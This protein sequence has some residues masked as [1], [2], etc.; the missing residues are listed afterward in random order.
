MADEET[1]E[2]YELQDNESWEERTLNLLHNSKIDQGFTQ[3]NGRKR[4]HKIS[5][6]KKRPMVIPSVILELQNQL[7]R[8]SSLRCLSNFLLEVV[9]LS[10]L[11]LIYLC[12][13]IWVCQLEIML[14]SIFNI[15]VVSMSTRV[16]PNWVYF[17]VGKFV[18]WFFF[19]VSFKVGFHISNFLFLTIIVL[20]ILMI[21]VFCN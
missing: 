19:F 5:L 2:F 20:S 6:M 1:G 12:M 15:W 13:L 7:F 10:L 3:K 21:W 11:S 4:K 9:F 14:I 18:M 17:G 8:E 16:L